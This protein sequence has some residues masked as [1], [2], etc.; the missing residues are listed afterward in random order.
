MGGFVASCPDCQLKTQIFHSCSDRHCPVCQGSKQKLWA[1]AQIQNSLPI[2]YFHIVFTIP[3]FLNPLFLSNQKLCYDILFDAS[4]EA[5]A[6]L[7]TSLKHLK[8]NPGFT[9]VL[10]TWSQTL[11]YHPHIHVMIPSGGLSK[12]GERFV[13][14]KSTF[15][16]PVKILSAVFKTIL[17]EKLKTAFT[18]QKHFIEELYASA[19]VVNI[20]KPFKSSSNVIKYLAKYTQ[21][22]AITNSRIISFDKVSHMLTFSY[23]DNRD[24]GKFKEMTLH[25]LEFMRRFFMHILP[26]GFTKMRHYGFLALR[27][28][29]ENINKIFKLLSI[30]REISN[31][32]RV[33]FLL[34]CSKCSGSLSLQKISAWDFHIARLKAS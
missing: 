15:F 20:K 31:S 6:T 29:R 19:F 25:V 22:V 8:F 2:P 24:G 3:D 30:K 12:D 1:D 28:K 4:C 21:K 18:L 23:K 14:S 32:Q 26:K 7:C 9:S 34:T 5:I 33:P 13:R 27:S 17:I 10:H 16:I 11:K